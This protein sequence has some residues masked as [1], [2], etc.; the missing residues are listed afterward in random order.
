MA[1]QPTPLQEAG[2]Q[3]RAWTADDDAREL[4][5]MILDELRIM[6]LHLSVMTDNVF[7]SK[8]VE[9]K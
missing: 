5:R 7:D 4:L 2:G 6:N 8:D 3:Q 9:T 1:Y